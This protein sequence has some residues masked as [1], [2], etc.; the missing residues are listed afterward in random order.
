MTIL[1]DQNSKFNKN[2]NLCDDVVYCSDDFLALKAELLEAYLECLKAYNF[3]EMKNKK[4]NSQFAKI[5]VLLE[6]LLKV[7]NKSKYKEKTKNIFLEEKIVN[8]KSKDISKDIY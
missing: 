4:I 5:S 1:K 2:I 8:T 7:E 3:Y 6:M